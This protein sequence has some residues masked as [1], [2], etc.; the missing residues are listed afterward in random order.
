MAANIEAIRQSNAIHSPLL[1]I[2]PAEL[3]AEIYEHVLSDALIELKVKDIHTRTALLRTCSQ[4]RSEAE[5][6]FY[7]KNTFAITDA[8]GQEYDVKSFLETIGKDNALSLAHIKLLQ[9]P[10]PA[11]WTKFLSM[12]ASQH[13]AGRTGPQ[14][15]KSVKEELGTKSTT[16][17]E[18]MK[19][20]QA[21]ILAPVIRIATMLGDSD[22]PIGNISGHFAHHKDL[23]PISEHVAKH[24]EEILRKSFA[25]QFEQT[26]GETYMKKHGYL[27]MVRDADQ[28]KFGRSP[29]KAEDW[30]KP[31]S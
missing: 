30:P 26:V 14:I 21:E 15:A 20:L 8:A 12:T 2:L 5:P 22:V 4:I 28:L 3:R 13:A 29:M 6:I 17:V 24:G 16:G 25:V 7:S 1:A 19:E 9:V 23:G 31:S 10:V 18:I 11:R 27:W